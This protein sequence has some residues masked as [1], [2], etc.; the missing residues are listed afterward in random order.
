MAI[1]PDSHFEAIAARLRLSA[2]GG[3][4][5]GRMDSVAERV[6][7]V[8]QRIA[9]R[10]SGSQM[11]FTYDEGMHASGWWKN[12]DYERCK[13]LSLSFFDPKTLEPAPHDRSLAARW[14]KVFFHPFESLIWCE[15]P[16]TDHGKRGDIFHYRVFCDPLWQPIKPRGEVY[17]RELTE[18]G[19]KSWSDIHGDRPLPTVAG[20]TIDAT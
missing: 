3:R 5:S 9:D 2:L 20:E 8:R 1:I 15:G 18:A 14:C 16:F 11:I 19:W 13:H 10:A 4:Y 6:Y 7:F 12:P 17:S